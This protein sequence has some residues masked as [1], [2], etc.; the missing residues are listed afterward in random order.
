M[1]SSELLKKIPLEFVPSKGADH[2]V[3]LEARFDT[4]KS[5]ERDL[6]PRIETI[7]LKT[8]TTGEYRGNDETEI[9]TCF[10]LSL[11]RSWGDKAVRPGPRSWDSG[12]KFDGRIFSQTDELIK[13]LE[14]GDIIVASL[15]ARSAPAN[16]SY[17]VTG[18]LVITFLDKEIDRDVASYGKYR[19]WATRSCE[20]RSRDHNIK[21]EIWFSTP[22]LDS[23][24]IS[25]L[26]TIQI[27]TESRDQ[28]FVSDP[29]TASYSWFD[30]VIL[31]PSE[32]ARAKMSQGL[33]CAWRSHTNS[34]GSPHLEVLEGFVFGRKH[35]LWNSLKEGDAIAVRASSR[36]G[37]WANLANDGCLELRFS[38]T[39]IKHKATAAQTSLVEAAKFKQM[40]AAYL[41]NAVLKNKI[42]GYIIEL[43]PVVLDLLK[44]PT[45]WDQARN[46]EKP[47]L[48]LLSLDGGG[49]RGLLSLHMLDALMER[50][51]TNKNLK[52]KPKPCQV[53]DL[54][55]GTSTGGLIA[56]MLGRL[57]M[58][59][60]DCITHY[61][62][63]SIDV[64]GD[65]NDQRYEGWWGRVRQGI[66]QVTSAFQIALA[67]HL[68]DS[69]KL[70]RAIR[71]VIQAT[72]PSKSPDATMWSDNKCRAIVVAS[73]TDDVS[74]E[75]P[76]HFRTYW[77]K[78]GDPKEYKIWEAAMATTAAPAYFEPIQIGD[79]KYVDG[80]IQA[81]NPVIQT[82]SESMV[83]FDGPRPVGCLISLGTGMPS[84][85]ALEYNEAF[86]A[87]LGNTWSL[88]KAILHQLTN[89]HR[90][91]LD[92]LGLNVTNKLAEK[93]YR[94]NPPLKLASPKDDAGWENKYV[95]LDN[96]AMIP[97]Y[98]EAANAYMLQNE[99]QVWKEECARIL[100]ERLP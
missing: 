88:G 15:W 9:F 16:H 77:T 31:P 54:I 56:L 4:T 95:G 87:G 37:A 67:N 65:Q 75:P 100:G 39:E 28:G 23:A 21:S 22:P 71:G 18:E 24:T 14:F 20:L 97:K 45:S 72:D 42:G 73:R 5:L 85:Q 10:D 35:D 52:K 84:K 47:E 79:Y 17:T 34:I 8:T 26:D 7:Q 81:N 93:Y 6:L 60:E 89:S 33:E 19:Y 25:K 74:T 27:F 61:K 69:S 66:N 80:G 44:I 91:H 53:F 96:T 36:F 2:R 41:S 40:L 94:F 92:V 59:V 68:Y 99:Q 78:T 13:Q 30:L 1:S 82:L 43:D 62:N 48:M 32:D 12:N 90:A 64:F 58:S 55:V 29:Y 57:E 83:A 51:K 76:T 86:W 98:E 3:L 46:K 38:P 70:K 11:H 50:I 63:L 49:V